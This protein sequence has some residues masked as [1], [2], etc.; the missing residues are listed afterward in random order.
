MVI[1]LEFRPNYEKILVA[2]LLLFSAGL[3]E[4][5]TPPE[6]SFKDMHDATYTYIYSICMCVCARACV[7]Q[8]GKPSTK[9]R[10]L[11]R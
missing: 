1:I 11:Q 9:T 7:G 10:R 6:N 2:I 3:P 8:G 4:R 5:K